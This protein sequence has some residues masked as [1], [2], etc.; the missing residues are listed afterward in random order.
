MIVAGFPGKQYRCYQYTYLMEE[1]RH[2]RLCWRHLR[3]CADR[4]LSK[5]SCICCGQGTA[6]WMSGYRT[7]PMENGNSELGLSCSG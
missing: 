5:W 3:D 1:Y 7:H 2:L 4:S 6:K